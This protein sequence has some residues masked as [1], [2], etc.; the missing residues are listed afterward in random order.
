MRQRPIRLRCLSSGKR[1]QRASGHFARR[2]SSMGSASCQSFRSLSVALCHQLATS[3]SW[4]HQPH[5]QRGM[6]TDTMGV[7]PPPLQMGQ[8]LGRLLFGGPGPACESGLY[9]LLGTSV[10]K[11]GRS[12]QSFVYLVIFPRTD[13]P[14]SQYSLE[15]LNATCRRHTSEVGPKFGIIILNQVLGCVPILGGFTELLCHPSVNVKIP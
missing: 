7:G 10:Q 14:S 12:K 13:V 8:Q 2:P 9:W 1:R 5:P 11:T 3:F 15:N 6:G 4:L